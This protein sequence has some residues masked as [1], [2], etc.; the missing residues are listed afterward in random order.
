MYGQT[1]KFIALLL[2][3]ILS[4]FFS[5]SEVAFFSLDKK[6]V[7]ELLKDNP[8][9][10][11][12]AGQLLDF[13]RRLLVTILIGNNIVNVAASIVSVSIA[14]SFA[15]VYNISEEMALTLEIILLTGVIVLFGELIPKIWASKS[16]ITF[17][18]VLTIPLF[19]ISSVFHP[20]S[21]LI[22]ELIRFISKVIKVDKS[23]N[24]ITHED[25]HHL[26]DLGHEHGTLE[27]HEQELIQSLVSVK[28]VVVREI[29]RPRVDMVAV[30]IDSSLDD[31]LQLISDSGHSRIP[32]YR[33]DLDDIMGVIY[34][35]DLLRFLKDKTHNKEIF[36]L[37]KIARKTLFIPETKLIN[38]LMKEF[39]EKKMHLAIVVDEYGGTSGLVTLEDIIE[40]I[41]GEIR[42][43]Y[44]KE[45]IDIV[46]ISANSYM[47]SGSVSITELDEQFNLDID[48]EEAD[49]DTLGGFVFN[50]AEEIP[51]EGY[52]FEFNGNR[53]TVKEVANKRIKKIQIDLKND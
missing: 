1:I 41:I 21:E 24:A 8:L 5:G 32:L 42:D 46:K 48:L 2:L 44:D 50:F 23:K 27:E 15:V 10:L 33:E 31:V 51:K 6:K 43:E 34:A 20:V 35:K 49:F 52:S 37:E 36:D 40:E 16:T 7:K 11:R 47:V 13:P 28:T 12:Y 25:L 14:L 53:F 30:S 9:L 45:E 3:I 19:W 17:I 39:Q 18:K 4:A 22:T 38:D 29:M 26:A